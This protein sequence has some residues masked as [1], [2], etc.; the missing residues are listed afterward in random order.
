MNTGL[1]GKTAIITGASRGIGK[2]IAIALANEGVRTVLCARG[3]EHLKQTEEEIKE[4]F[5][6][7]VISIK[8]NVSRYN[9]IKRTVNKALAKFKRIDI[10]INNAGSLIAGGI[11]DFDENIFLEQLYTRLI[12]IIRFSSEVI[13]IMKKQGGGKIIN[14]AGFSGIIPDSRFMTTS[15]LNSAI[16]NFTK[17]L[18][19]ELANDNINV[20]V[21]NPAYTNTEHIMQVLNK[22]AE[23]ENRSLEELLNYTNSKS[24][25]S[26]LAAPED[27]ASAV[28]YIASDSAN[29][30]T[31]VSLNI[32]SGIRYK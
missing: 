3:E 28:V 11:Q 12:S 14:I 21:I 10:L 31:G 13:P 32:D 24:P 29:Y 26:R 23:K 1:H 9:D 15:I 17:S 2:A 30:L 7:E 25:F 8:A 16:I 18:A 27:V 5:H 4:R 20:N 6:T 22:I 19:M